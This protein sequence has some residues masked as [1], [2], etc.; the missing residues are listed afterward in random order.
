VSL[1]L[2]GESQDTPPVPVVRVP[3][4]VLVRGSRVAGFGGRDWTTIDRI[5]TLTA[6]P[7]S[8]GSYWTANATLVQWTGG[9]WIQST[10]SGLSLSWADVRGFANPSVLVYL[11][12]V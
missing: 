1:T 7:E 5:W 11:A 9:R 4:G 6:D 2:P 12:S 10:V 8:S 3:G